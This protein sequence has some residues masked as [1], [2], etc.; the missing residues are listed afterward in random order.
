MGFHGYPSR[1]SSVSKVEIKAQ[2]PTILSLP[3]EISDLIFENLDIEDILHLSLISQ[4]FLDISKRHIQ[5]YFLSF[6][7]LWSGESIICIGDYTEPGD[8]PPGMLTEDEKKE[9]E[10]SVDENGQPI[11]L[12][13]CLHDYYKP[14]FPIGFPKDL[15]CQLFNIKHYFK[16]PTHRRRQV[17]KAVNVNLSDFYPP[18]QPWILR[19]LTTREYVRADAIALNP[20]QIQGPHIEGVGFGEVILSRIC[21]STDPSIAMIYDGNIHKGI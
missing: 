13:S 7:G 14:E 18:N 1:L 12:A 6:M 4:H 15:F 9:L 3:T 20:E 16:I 21:W 2:R 19:N 17:E 10:E 11:T 8:Y 5:N